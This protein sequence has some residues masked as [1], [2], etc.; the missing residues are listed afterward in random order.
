MIDVVLVGVGSVMKNPK[1]EPLELIIWSLQWLLPAKSYSLKLFSS[2]K[3]GSGRRF[4]SQDFCSRLIKN[5]P[6]RMDGEFCHG[7]GVWGG[8]R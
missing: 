5:F 2:V 8:R 3:L 7:T 4:L 1:G 6:I